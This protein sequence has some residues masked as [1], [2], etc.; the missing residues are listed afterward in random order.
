MLASVFLKYDTTKKQKLLITIPPRMIVAAK[1]V[2]PRK[3]GGKRKANKAIP[4]FIVFV[5][6]M[7]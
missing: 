7:P 1:R 6:A 5:F 4:I 3:V 2:A